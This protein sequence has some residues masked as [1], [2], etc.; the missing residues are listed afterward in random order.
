MK[1]VTFQAQISTGD[2]VTITGYPTNT[3]GLVVNKAWLSCGDG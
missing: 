1:P 2:T 3:P